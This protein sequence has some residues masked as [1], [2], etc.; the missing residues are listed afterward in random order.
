MRCTRCGGFTVHDYFYGATDYFAWQCHGL[1][2]LNC[3]SVTN[4]NPIED[5]ARPRSD[6]KRRS[7]KTEYRPMATSSPTVKS[8]STYD[9]A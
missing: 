8:G 2:C 5:T 7:D 1:R 6:Q 4:V 3:G 9:R